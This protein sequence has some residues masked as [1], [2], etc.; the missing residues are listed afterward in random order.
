MAVAAVLATMASFVLAGPLDLGVWLGQLGGTTLAFAVNHHRNSTTAARLAPFDVFDS[1]LGAAYA[2]FI[3]V[4]VG[5]LSDSALLASA[6]VVGLCALWNNRWA[7]PT[8]TTAQAQILVEEAVHAVWRADHVLVHNVRR[9]RFHPLWPVVSFRVETDPTH[10][11]ERQRHQISWFFG[12][13]FLL[14]VLFG[15][16][17]LLPHTGS[18]FDSPVPRLDTSTP[19]WTA[20]TSAHGRMAFEAKAHATD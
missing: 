18:S 14:N 12:R 20:P 13:P 16:D 4:V 19:V 1:W 9:Q 6:V 17:S 15:A 7:F 2:T 3:G 11:D 5:L 8:L 10:S